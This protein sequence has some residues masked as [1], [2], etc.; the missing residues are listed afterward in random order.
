MTIVRAV[1]MHIIKDEE[2]GPL[3]QTDLRDFIS[4]LSTMTDLNPEET[5][6]QLIGRMLLEASKCEEMLDA[7]GAPN[8]EY[9]SPVRMTAAL[10]KAFSRVIYNLFH[11][12]LSAD[13]YQL[14]EV[15]GD[16]I[17]ATR[18]STNM[19]MSSFSTASAS[20]MKLAKK[21]NLDHD[22]RPLEDF[23]FHDPP[24]EGVLQANRKGRSV[25]KPRD[26]AVYLATNLLNLA[27]KSTW[28][29]IYR[30]IE[31]D[32]YHTCIPDVVSEERLRSLSNNF[33][34]LQSLY[35]TYLSGSDIAEMDKNL[36]VMRGH[37]TVIFHL[38]DTA[39]TLTHFYERHAS[40]NWNKKLKPPISNK[41][42]L[43]I[44]IG[45]FVA[46]S[47]KYI[48]AATELCRDILKSYAVQ[49]E[50]VVPIPN[51][52]GFHVRPSTLIAKIAIHYGSEVTML[53]GS[54]VYDASLPLEL[55]RANEELNRRKRDAVARY[56]M[57]HKLIKND[58]GATYDEPLMKKILRVIFLD[59]LEKQKIMIYNNDFSFEDLTPYENETLAEFIKRAIALYLAMGK[60]DIVSDD[61]VSFQGDM[62]VLED[63][64]TLAE[65]GYGE[66]K[67]GNNIVLPPE[68]SYLKR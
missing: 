16:F 32:Q 35:D 59:L 2:L 38:L 60:I 54:A 20:F 29:D 68:L 61:T 27:E 17:G 53:L 65:H 18:E 13:G 48:I 36:P 42:L 19:L 58:A 33:H 47:D 67:F 3:I 39:E 66:D 5:P 49:G 31:P 24:M 14:M 1:A 43:G 9:W 45:Y 8:N 52:R 57:E 40:K 37:I 25:H 46:Y 12:Y 55:F 62:R 26:T 6:R 21:M 10:A 22:L 44:I 30:K 4:L 50:I 41:E 15:D 56:V 7:F 64:R 34:S 63:I 23:H 11:I 51:Y 28:L